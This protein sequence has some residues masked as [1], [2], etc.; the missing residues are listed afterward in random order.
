MNKPSYKYNTTYKIHEIN[1]LPDTYIRKFPNLPG[2]FLL[3]F[4]N[5]TKHNM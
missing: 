4:N 1:L 3:N 5:F 2:F